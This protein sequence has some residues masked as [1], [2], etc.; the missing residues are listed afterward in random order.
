MIFSASVTAKLYSRNSVARR[1]WLLVALAAIA[2][3]LAF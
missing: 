2:M 1:A 3:S